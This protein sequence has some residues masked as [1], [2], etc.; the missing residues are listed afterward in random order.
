MTELLAVPLEEGG[1]IVVET[2]EG[3]GGVLKAARPGEIVGQA[4]RTL[5]SALDAVA[6]AARAVVDKLREAAPADITVEF[7]LRLTAEAGVVV[8]RTTGECNFRVMLRWERC[9]GSG[10]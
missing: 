7:G 3:Q 9:D 6:P 8:T 10:R 1:T 2:V 4:A 5:E